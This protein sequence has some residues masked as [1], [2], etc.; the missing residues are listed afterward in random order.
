[1]KFI[2]LVLLFCLLLHTTA[3]EEDESPT[4]G[5][6]T[7]D[8]QITGTVQLPPSASVPLEQTE[9]LSVVGQ[10]SLQ[11][12]GTFTL[13]VSEEPGDQVVFLNHHNDKTLL[14]GYLSEGE[15]SITMNVESTALALLMLH[16]MF[17]KLVETVAQTVVNGQELLDPNNTALF[18]T[19]SILWNNPS[20]ARKLA[21][22]SKNDP[23][24]KP[25]RP[26]RLTFKSGNWAVTY[27]AGIYSEQGERIETVILPGAALR[28]T[29]ALE[30]FTR[31]WT[32]PYSFQFILE[33]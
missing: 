9:V 27:V 23:V 30:W 5:T 32:F 7:G 21:L 17:P 20:N 25:D 16:P 22:H 6:S 2:K 8:H 13:T 28:N 19:L 14:M 26:A 24:V 31:I 15:K 11:S 33:E 1:M 10:Q 18:E 29:S 12:S 3:C 4:G